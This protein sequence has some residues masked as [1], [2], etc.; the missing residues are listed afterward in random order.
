MLENILKTDYWFAT[1]P[2]AFNPLILK[3]LLVVFIVIIILAIISSLLFLKKPKDKLSKKIWS[4]L[5]NWLYAFGIVNLIFVFFRQERIPY[6]SMR[7]I[8]FLWL[9]ASFIWLIFI[10]RF[11]FLKIPKVKR[12]QTQKEELEKYLPK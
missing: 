1:K 10:L 5:T 12:E 11:M 3:I 6:L 2:L 7:L 4:K 8:M 9:L